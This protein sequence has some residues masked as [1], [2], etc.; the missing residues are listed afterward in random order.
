MVGSAATGVEKLKEVHL[1]GSDVTLE[2]VQRALQG[3]DEWWTV[4]FEQA[5]LAMVVGSVDGQVLAASPSFEKMFGYSTDEIR[6]T[7]GIIAMTHP[8]DVQADIDLFTELI[9]GEREHYQLTKRYYHKNGTLIWGR[10]TVLLLRDAMGE[11]RF[12][13]A[14]TQDITESVTA[15]RLAQ[16]LERAALRREQALELNDNIVQGLVVVKMALEGGW[17]DK[18]K[19]TLKRTLEKARGIVSDLLGDLE[20]TKQVTLT[21]ESPTE[22]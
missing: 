15:E 2:D 8:E 20:A 5:G 1:S 17:D 9:A 18:A 4:I 11:P 14:L 19:E 21:R 16:E 22:I 10:L 12:V 7:G 6:T 3:S 13:V